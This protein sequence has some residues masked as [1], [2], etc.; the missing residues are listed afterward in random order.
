MRAIARAV[1]AHVLDPRVHAALE[2]A[3]EGFLSEN[4]NVN[5]VIAWL[6][7]G[8]DG[9]RRAYPP[10]AGMLLVPRRELHLVLGEHERSGGG[11]NM[12]HS[13]ASL[14]LDFEDS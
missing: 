11:L 14:T 9:V 6:V 1:L 5:S 13:L 10:A 12:R 2:N 4:N 8:R 7:V 3:L